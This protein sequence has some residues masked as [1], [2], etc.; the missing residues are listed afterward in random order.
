MKAHK[1][2]IFP[3]GLIIAF[4]NYCNVALATALI[5]TEVWVGD[6]QVFAIEGGVH[7]CPLKFRVACLLEIIAENAEVVASESTITKQ[8]IASE[9]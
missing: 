4:N 9:V 6:V 2:H 1:I 3:I 8:L 7:S 5:D